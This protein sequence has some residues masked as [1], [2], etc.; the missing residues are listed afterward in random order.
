MNSQNNSYS[1][2]ENPVLIREVSLHDVKVGVWCAISAT[3]IITPFLN[4]TSTPICNTYSNTIFWTPV[5]LRKDLRLCELWL[6]PVLFHWCELLG[7][8]AVV[9]FLKWKNNLKGISSDRVFEYIACDW[10]GCTSTCYVGSAE[11]TLLSA[12]RA[13]PGVGVGVVLVFFCTCVP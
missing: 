5:R 2:A 4:P 1:S 6:Y 8:A 12:A 10:L 11:M 13:P 3:I 7:I 9:G